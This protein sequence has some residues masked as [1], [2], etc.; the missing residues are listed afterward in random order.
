MKQHDSTPDRGL[1][2]L[3]LRVH[4]TVF[5]LAVA[6]IVLAVIA[7]LLDPV[8]FNASV[9]RLRGG[10]LQHFDSFIMIMGNLFVVLCMR[11]RAFAPRPDSTGRSAGQAAVRLRVVVLDDVRRRHGRRPAVLGRGRA[12]GGVHRLAGHTL[13]RRAT[14]ARG[15]TRRDGFRAVPLG[16]APVGRLPRHGARGGLLRVQQ[17]LALRDELGAVAADRASSRRA[18]RPGRRHLH[19]GV[20]HVRPR[21]VAGS[22]RDAVGR[23]HA[24]RPRHARWSRDAGALHRS[25]LPDGRVLGLDRHRGRH[26]AS[27]QPQH[28]A[29]HPAAGVLCR[30]DGHRRLPDGPP[31]WRWRT[32]RA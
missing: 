5:P 1:E 4:R 24:P 6:L 18:H 16:P 25:G 15:G 31:G 23:R 12:G 32:T 11:P 26:P 27:L 30:G 8:G 9:A 3:G 2:F 19:R 20:D 17:G 29:R 28:G 22:R 10:I 13:E 14:N 7:A 21:D